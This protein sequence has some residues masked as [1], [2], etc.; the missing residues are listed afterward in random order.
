MGFSTGRE[1]GEKEKFRMTSSLEEW[2]RGNV[3]DLRGGQLKECRFMVEGITELQ[4][5][6]C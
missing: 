5:L 4:F 1:R 3:L 6:T 2:E